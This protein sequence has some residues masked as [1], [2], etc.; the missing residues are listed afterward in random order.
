MLN[1]TYRLK[2]ALNLPIKHLG[3]TVTGHKAFAGA[4]LNKTIAASDFDAIP[5]FFPEH[6]E[7]LVVP[8]QVVNSSTKQT[9]RHDAKQTNL[10][11]N[12]LSVNKSFR[13]KTALTCKY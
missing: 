6:H 13:H 3:Q 7:S 11:Q 4:L 10:F 5:N 12:S 8:T 2:T 1:Q 9:I